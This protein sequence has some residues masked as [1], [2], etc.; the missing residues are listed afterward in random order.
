MFG[1]TTTLGPYLTYMLDYIW[2][3]EDMVDYGRKIN[4]N[5]LCMM[6]DWGIVVSVRSLA[7]NPPGILEVVLLGLAEMVGILLIADYVWLEC[8]KFKQDRQHKLPMKKG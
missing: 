6:V 1:I 2:G 8:A 7:P 4:R 3:G 5:V